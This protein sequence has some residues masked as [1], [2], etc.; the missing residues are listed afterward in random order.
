MVAGNHDFDD[1]N[2]NY[3]PPVDPPG[4]N[5][6]RDLN[7]GEYVGRYFTIPNVS[8]PAPKNAFVVRM[9]RTDETLDGGVGT[10]VQLCRTCLDADRLSIDN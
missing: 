8:A 10:S 5:E 6:Y 1:P 7:T 3:Q 2:L 4:I 9:R